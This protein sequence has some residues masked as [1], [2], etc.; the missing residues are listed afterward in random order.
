M[1][2]RG[3]MQD[4]E[5]THGTALRKRQLVA[6]V[7]DR[8]V[9]LLV[10]ASATGD[11][12][13]GYE[14]GRGLGVLGCPARIVATPDHPRGPLPQSMFPLTRLRAAPISR[15]ARRSPH[16]AYGTALRQQRNC[17]AV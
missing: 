16:G 10:V 2:Y 13:P 5:W 11:N 7:S 9:G 1:S 12:S 6:V 3:A 17:R 8:S 14:I 15:G 4:G